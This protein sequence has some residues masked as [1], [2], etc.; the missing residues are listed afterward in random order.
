MCTSEG[1]KINTISSIKKKSVFKLL[2]VGVTHDNHIVVIH[3]GISISVFNST[4]YIQL[5]GKIVNTSTS[6]ASKDVSNFQSLDSIIEHPNGQVFV[7]NSASHCIHAFNADLSYFWSF[8]G[9]GDTP[10][11]FNRP[12]SLAFDSSGNGYVSD[13]I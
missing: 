7:V 13:S 1:V 6:F 3:S 4:N 9:K 2:C 5:D 10:G 11:Q 12:Y 8:G